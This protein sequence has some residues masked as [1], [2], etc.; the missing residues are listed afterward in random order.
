MAPDGLVPAGSTKEPAGLT[1]PH[2]AALAKLIGALPVSDLVA[3]IEGRATA[4]TFINLAE[5]A[6][7]I[8]AAAFP[9]AA[10]VA[11]EIELGLEALRFLFGAAGLAKP[12]RITPG[13]NPLRGG[14]QGARG[15]I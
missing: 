3:L 6:A 9:P 14:F 11:G 4:G 1:T 12:I 8:V 7:G 15:H 5:Q 10:F 2:Y 13:Q